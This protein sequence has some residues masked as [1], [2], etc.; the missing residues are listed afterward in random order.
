[1]TKN[2]GT[3]KGSAILS[4]TS[5][6]PGYSIST[7]AADCKTGSK[8]AQVPGSVCHGCYALKGSYRYP[9]VKEAMAKRQEFMTTPKWVELMVASINRTQSPYFRWFDSGDLQSV[10]QGHQILEVCELTPSKFHWIPTRETKLWKTVLLQRKT[11]LPSNVVIR[12]SSTM[13]NDSPLKSFYNTSTVHDKHYQGPA[14]GH[15]CPASKQDGKCGECRAC[16]NPEVK[17]VSYPKH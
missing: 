4:N 9:A 3:Y 1:M 10:K 2:L 5:K 12:A 14:L 8:L 15:I 16:W 6:M 11:W 13:V 17:N 7:P